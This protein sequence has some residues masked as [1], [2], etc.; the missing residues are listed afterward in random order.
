VPQLVPGSPAVDVDS[1]V[2]VPW[3]VLQPARKMTI[4]PPIPHRLIRMRDGSAV[5]E[6]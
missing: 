3:Y 6:L 5:L 1:L 4:V 2:E